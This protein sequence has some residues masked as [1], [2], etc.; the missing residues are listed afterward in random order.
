MAEEDDKTAEYSPHVT[1]ALSNYFDGLTEP[2]SLFIGTYDVSEG[3]LNKDANRDGNNALIIKTV[4]V[5]RQNGIDAVPFFDDTAKSPDKVV[6]SKTGLQT[7]FVAPENA[8]AEAANILSILERHNINSLGFATPNTEKQLLYPSLNDEI[9]DAA[10]VIDLEK[11]NPEPEQFQR[12]MAVHG[13]GFISTMLDEAADAPNLKALD[14]Q[15][16]VDMDNQNRLTG[17]KTLYKG[18]TQGANVF[19]VISPYEARNV[20]HASPKIS[21][22]QGY[23]GLGSNASS[24][25]GATYI[26]KNSN[27]SYGF[28]YEIEARDDQ[29][30]YGNIG[31]ETAS[32]ELEDTY[33]YFE[34]PVMPHR[35][36]IKAMYLHIGGKGNGFLYKIPEND[37]R[38]QDF[39]ALHEP[40]DNTIFGNLAERRKQQ[41]DEAKAAGHAVTYEFRKNEALEIP[42]YRDLSNVS[43]EAF[44]KSIARRVDI[45]RDETGRLVVEGDVDLNNLDIRKLPK[46]FANTKINGSLDLSRNEKLEIS[47]LDQLPETSKGTLSYGG[48]QLNYDDLSSKST[49][50]VV[51][52]LCGTEA[53]NKDPDGFYP[54]LHIYGNINKLPNDFKDK[55]FEH[56]YFAHSVEFESFDDI[57]E[58]RGGISNLNVKNQD[59]EISPHEFLKKTC[60]NKYM[61]DL[62][63]KGVFYGGTLRG[64]MADFVPGE[65]P[66]SLDFSETNIHRFP[67]GM[68]NI[69][70]ERLG[71]NKDCKFETLDNFPTTRRGVYGLQLAGVSEKETAKS[72]LDKVYGTQKLADNAHTAQNGN[73]VIHNDLDLGRYD[74]NN[75]SPSAFP[76]DFSSVKIGGEFISGSTG[77]G[78]Y[79]LEEDRRPSVGFLKKDKTIDLSGYKD[80]IQFDWGDLGNAEQVVMPRE[81]DKVSLRNVKLP[82]ITLDCSGVKNLEISDHSDLSSAS[83]AMPEHAE[84]IIVSQSILPQG[85]L[86]IKNAKNLE[87]NR[88]DL[89]KTDLLISEVSTINLSNMKLN[90]N[91]ELDASKASWL[92]LHNCDLSEVKDFKMPETSESTLDFYDT[93]LPKGDYDFSKYEKELYM[94]RVDFTPDSTLK[95]PQVEISPDSLG[96]GGYDTK[97]P[98]AFKFRIEY[99]GVKFP[100]ME[101]NLFEVKNN[102]LSQEDFA[103]YK[104][105]CEKN[106]FADKNINLPFADLSKVKGFNLPPSMASL[107]VRST[108]FPEGA[109]DLSKA[110]LLKINQADFSKCE[111]IKLPEKITNLEIHQNKFKNGVELDVSGVERLSVWAQDFADVKSLKLNPEGE[112]RIGLSK[113]SEGMELDLSKNKSITIT[114]TDMSQLKLL[115]LPEGFIMEGNITES[116]LPKDVFI[117]QERY[118]APQEEKTEEI[119]RVEEFHKVEEKAMEKVQAKPAHQ[120]TAERVPEK[121]VVKEQA[122]NIYNLSEL[123]DSFK[124]DRQ[125]FDDG[126]GIVID[127][128]KRLLNKDLKAIGL[129]REQR[130]SIIMNRRKEKMAKFFNNIK[131]SMKNNKLTQVIQKLRGIDTYSQKANDDDKAKIWDFTQQQTAEGNTTGSMFVE[132]AN[133]PEAGVKTDQGDTPKVSKRIKH[134][135]NIARGIMQP[136]K[137][138]AQSNGSQSNTLSQTA[139]AKEAA[140][141]ISR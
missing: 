54:R 17:C 132:T 86:E 126:D 76:R 101:W 30:Y 121:K 16:A 8:K 44:L 55:K 91:S 69:T 138:A 113:M 20:P 119:Q 13:E 14:T 40:S 127:D 71:L 99:P 114:K 7:P 94:N 115:R 110:K 90:S 84:E 67:Q 11:A 116:K 34:T 112:I 72:F 26:D 42:D 134:L 31:L 139:I 51:R 135:V 24:K 128:Q 61:G 63:Y 28:I 103:T 22:A 60:G 129:T 35:N 57:P 85:K 48:T 108:V 73:I 6:V 38:W 123:Y 4:E 25:G 140:N 106:V 82:S 109:L 97:I 77:W 39:M 45:H 74:G 89:N 79:A 70:C 59:A 50:E 95:L 111:Q 125:K 117:G 133:T 15:T 81:I 122:P 78:E 66:V 65:L 93:T 47:S 29:K 5:L 3:A 46:D 2:V 10:K 96:W 41:K 1:R 104:E 43:T 18:G 9:M 12:I 141:K 124:Y 75:I 120:T 27:R 62:E 21:I 37:S 49:E 19:A 52:K 130:H 98:K 100:E 88:A 87:L 92:R 118:I 56:I 137:T 105:D 23:S 107:D 64:K 80:E 33:K 53:L 83:L 32:S 136:Q 131:E 58:T 68:E 36:K 102:G